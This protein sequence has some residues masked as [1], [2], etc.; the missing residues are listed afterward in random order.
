LR[1][2]TTVQLSITAQTVHDALVVP[3]ESVL[4]ADKNAAQVMV[5]DGQSEAHSREVKTGIQTAEE[6]QIVSGLQAGEQVVSQGAYGLPDKT[7]VKVEKDEAASPSK[8]SPAKNPAKDKDE[9]DVATKANG[10]G[11]GEK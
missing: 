1:P 6:V 5:I 11:G 10:K 7:K 9:D 8:D 2:G 4:N 3:S